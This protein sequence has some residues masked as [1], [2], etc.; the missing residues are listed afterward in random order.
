MADS[1]ALDT[2][3]LGKLSSDSTLMALA[4][5][6]VWSDVAASGKTRFVVVSLSTHEDDYAF[7]GDIEKATYIVK[8]VMLDTNPTNAK[9]AAARIHTLLQNVPLTVSGF[10]HLLLRRSERIRY[11]E[12]DAL[13]NDARWQHHGGRYDAWVSQ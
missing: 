9:T 11:T 7:D 6:G 13:N 1:A 8:A 12:V 4:P 10:D 3:I 2:A 5:D